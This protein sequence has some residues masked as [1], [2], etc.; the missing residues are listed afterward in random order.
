MMNEGSHPD[1]DEEARFGSPRHHCFRQP[2]CADQ[3]THRVFRV[4]ENL[5]NAL[6]QLNAARV[7]LARSIGSL[8]TLQERALIRHPFAVESTS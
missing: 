8:Q 4:R 6:L 3:W 1:G 7:N 5:V 2:L